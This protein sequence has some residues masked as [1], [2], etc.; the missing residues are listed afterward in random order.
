MYRWIITAACF[1]S[2]ALNGCT[3]TEEPKTEG[4]GTD[5]KASTETTKSGMPSETM[6]AAMARC[7]MCD[8]DHKKEEMKKVNGSLYCEDCGCAEK[9]AKAKAEKP[10]EAKTDESKTA[11]GGEAKTEKPAESKTD[12]AKPKPK[13]QGA[14]GTPVIPRE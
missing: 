11:K 1:A 5:S 13:T 3:P 12:E 2:L 6:E 10:V 9:A 14:A 8:M 4:N 7:S